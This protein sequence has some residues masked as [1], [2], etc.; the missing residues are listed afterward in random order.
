M[1]FNTIS[2]KI[3]DDIGHLVLTQPPENTMN[4]EFFDEF[5]L[6]TREVLPTASFKAMVVYGKGRHFS[7]G[8]NPQ[9][10]LIEGGK[11]FGS[12][13]NF[14]GKTSVCYC[15]LNSLGNDFFVGRLRKY[16]FKS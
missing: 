13:S 11:M 7:A 10:L 16:H 12:K 3:E 14:N 4:R 8:A 9:E 5:T 15:R 2:W 1:T 6:L